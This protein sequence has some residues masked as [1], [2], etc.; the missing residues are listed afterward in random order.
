MRV[1]LQA[2]VRR[3]WARRPVLLAVPA[4]PERAGLAPGTGSRACF[5]LRELGVSKEFATFSCSA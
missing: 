3:G 5:Q 1:D 4:A 2:E